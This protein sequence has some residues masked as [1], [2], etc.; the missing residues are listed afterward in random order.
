MIGNSLKSDIAPALDLGLA[1][2]WINRDR[3]ESDSLIAADFEVAD[4]RGL[5]DIL[6]KQRQTTNPKGMLSTHVFTIASLSN[7]F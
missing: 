6:D 7:S 1:T 3:S 5:T 2:I 4:P